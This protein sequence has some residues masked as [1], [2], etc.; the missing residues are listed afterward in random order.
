MAKHA[1]SGWYLEL[2]CG[3]PRP[4]ALVIDTLAQAFDAGVEWNA[5]G[6]AMLAIVPVIVL[7]ITFLWFVGKGGGLTAD[8]APARNRSSP[9]ARHVS[10]WCW[11]WRGVVSVL[12]SRVRLSAELK[13]K[14]GHW[15]ARDVLFVHGPLSTN[16]GVI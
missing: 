11:L 16:A 1:L 3:P 12:A 15:P 8:A 14:I 7:A 13:G 5:V 2:L 10:G 6:E 4:M 9:P